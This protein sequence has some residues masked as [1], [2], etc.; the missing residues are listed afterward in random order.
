M[1]PRLVFRPTTPQALAGMRIEPPPSEPVATGTMPAPTAEPDPP[2]DPP[3]IWLALQGVQVGPQASVSVVPMIPNSEVVVRPTG[4]MPDARSRRTSSDWARTIQPS[5]RRLPA[6]VGRPTSPWKRSLSSVGTPRNGPGRTRRRSRPRR[7]R[8]RRRL[9]PFRSPAR[10]RAR[11][12][13]PARPASPDPRGRASA[14]ASASCAAYSSS[15]IRGRYAVVRIPHSGDCRDGGHRVNWSMSDDVPRNDGGPRETSVTFRSV[16]EERPGDALSGLFDMWWPSYRRWFLRDGEAERP[17]YAAGA[18]RAAHPHARA[19]AG[20]RGAGGVGRRRRP[21]GAVPVAV[22]SAAVP[23][24]MLAGRL[25]ARR[26][27]VAAAH[28][29]LR[30]GAV[31]DDAPDHHLCIRGARWR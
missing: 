7:R 16:V 10:R 2:L 31:R 9:P 26:P 13:R 21:G 6:S 18:A 4:T 19:G 15:R 11:P 24:R 27:P 22:G 23:G 29:R 20:L 12:A 3:A 30:P 1:R 28:V 17:S 14:S 8:A 25:D 5:A